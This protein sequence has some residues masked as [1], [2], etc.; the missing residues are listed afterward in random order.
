MSDTFMNKFFRGVRH[1]L[2]SR[3][4][5]LNHLGRGACEPHARRPLIQQARLSSALTCHADGEVWAARDPVA[6]D[7]KVAIKK[8]HNCFV[9]ATEAKRILREL[10]I[11]RHISHPNVIRIRDVLHPQVRVA[12]PQGCER[13]RRATTFT[14]PTTLIALPCAALEPRSSLSTFHRPSS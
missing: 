14:H 12:P 10:R 2:E 8:I 7:E 11:L 6:C 3:Y 4:D 5:L 9:Q 13:R 1:D